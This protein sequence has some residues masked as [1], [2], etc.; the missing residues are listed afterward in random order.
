MVAAAGRTCSSSGGGL[1]ELPDD[2]LAL[3]SAALSPRD[4]V[5]MGATCRKLRGACV[6]DKLW[7]PHCERILTGVDLHSWRSAMSSF[8]CL[9]RFVKSVRSLLG[10]WV[11]QNPELGNLVYVTWGFVSVVGCRIIPQELGPDGLDK[12]LLWAPVF[13][14][15]GNLDGSL[16]F[17]LHGR[18]NEKQ[19]FCY[20]GRFHLSDPN[21]NVLLLEAEPLQRSAAHHRT[22]TPGSPTS[23]LFFSVGENSEDS[24]EELPKRPSK[25]SAKSSGKGKK[26]T[27][28][29][30]PFHRLGFGDRRRLLE[31]L[32]PKIAVPIPPLAS[33]P[34]FACNNKTAVV[35]KGDLQFLAERR[36]RLL[37]MYNCRDREVVDCEGSA[38]RTYR[39]GVDSEG[40]LRTLCTSTP[41]Q[42]S[43]APKPKPVRG[44]S[45]LNGLKSSSDGV[46][47]PGANVN[48]FDSSKRLGLARFVVSKM[49]QMIGKNSNEALGKL[50]SGS[51]NTEAKRMQLQEFLK[52]SR[53]IGLRLH[54]TSWSLSFYRAWP[55]MHN[56]QFALYKIPQQQPCEGRDYAGLWAGTFGWPPGRPS[57]DKAGK[58]LFF[59]KISYEET[60]EGR[61]LIATKILEGTQY[62]LHPNGSAMF[63]AKVDEP[64]SSVFPWSKD[65]DGNPVDIVQSFLGEGIANGYGFAYPGSKPGDLF[66]DKS[67]FLAFVWRESRAV[68]T[69]TRLDLQTCLENGHRVPALPPVANFAYLTKS[70]SN[71]FAG[72]GGHAASFTAKSVPGNFPVRA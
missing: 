41:I 60:I 63:V 4:V 10:L 46:V 14:I 2:V 23:P 31:V 64:S 11:H 43:S 65:K 67:G 35:S 7:L 36:A 16:A 26:K 71:V 13:E 33:G 8:Q 53:S 15:I 42:E 18:E 6:A 22:G 58:A 54:A 39:K 72:S 29:E 61:L 62:V 57:Q 45:L 59:L 49:K 12:G 24:G 28:A 47:P 34:L 17:F 66:V 50:A 25:P 44:T 3:L 38:T 9:W 32:A 5:A 1:Q 30:L 56:N 52:Q 27:Q 68:L 69:L 55:I 70:Y 51:S 48:A 40:L 19:E 37:W 21:P 20:P